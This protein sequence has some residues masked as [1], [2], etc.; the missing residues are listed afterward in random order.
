MQHQCPICKIWYGVPLGN[1][2]IG[3]KMHHSIERSHVPGH[4][5]ANGA[6]VINYSI[7]GGIQTV[8]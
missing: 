3:A 6:I 2:P 5:D 4:P 1:Q 8:S 7:P